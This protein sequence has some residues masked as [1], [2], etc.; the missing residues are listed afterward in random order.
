[1]RSAVPQSIRVS[2]S[3]PAEIGALE[4][5][6]R[7]VPGVQVGREAEAPGPGELGGAVDV[8]T[9]VASSGGLI[10]LIRTIPGYLRA[11][12]SGLSLHTVIKGKPFTLTAE[13]VDDVM[14]IIE[15]LL[16]E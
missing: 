2:V 9:A 15:R 4:E 13:N 1:M 12:R 14:P 6:F 7:Q 11:R 3:N 10:T 8:V 16:D 5:R